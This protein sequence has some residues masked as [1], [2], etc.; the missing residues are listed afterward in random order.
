MTLPDGVNGSVHHRPLAI[1]LPEDPS[2]EELAQYWTLSTQDKQEVFKCRG[3]AQR[4]RFA[5]QL[6]MLHTYGRFLPKAVPASRAAVGY[7]AGTLWR[8]SRAF[9]DRN[10]PFLSHSDL[11]GLAAL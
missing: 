9:G 6:C 11:S 4:R 8:R 2:Q 1:I 7:T 3:E 5:V 10:R